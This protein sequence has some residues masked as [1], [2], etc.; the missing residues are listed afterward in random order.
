MFPEK[1]EILD[2]LKLA[3][4]RLHKLQFL[5]QEGAPCPHLLRELELVEKALVSVK[6]DLIM[7]N[8]RSSLSVLQSNP[9]NHTKELNKILK[10]FTVTSD[11]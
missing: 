1:Q 2:R 5:V 8:L 11:F 9:K 6:M 10:L 3:A 4:F 7:C